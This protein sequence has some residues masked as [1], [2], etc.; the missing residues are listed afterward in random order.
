M[1]ECLIPEVVIIAWHAGISDV[2]L[3]Q[4]NSAIAY[5]N[6]SIKSEN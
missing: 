1:R 6:K 5:E 4:V 2:T 3:F